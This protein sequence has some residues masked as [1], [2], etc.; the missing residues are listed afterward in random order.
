M[1]T[2]YKL[3]NLLFK[4]LGRITL[5]ENNSYDIVYTTTKKDIKAIYNNS[6]NIIELMPQDDI[7]CLIKNI[8]QTENYFVEYCIDKYNSD[9]TDKLRELHKERRLLLKTFIEKQNN[10]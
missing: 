7:N 9:I 6:K 5:L 3:N 1:I 10:I 2:V 8:Q 4:I